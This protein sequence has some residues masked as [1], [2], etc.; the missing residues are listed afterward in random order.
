LVA[1]S[2]KR[3][4]GHEPPARPKKQTEDK[5]MLD[6]ETARVQR[7]VS[8]LNIERKNGPTGIRPLVIGQGVNYDLCLQ[9]TGRTLSLE[10]LKPTMSWE[11]WV[12]L[13]REPNEADVVIVLQD[14]CDDVV[15]VLFR[16]HD[17]FRREKI[18]A[19]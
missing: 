4:A 18:E 1:F 15:P 7:L 8:L 19:N 10:L 17:V 6:R 12:L 11:P 13:L 2:E 16:A 3:R 5:I 14:F 9:I